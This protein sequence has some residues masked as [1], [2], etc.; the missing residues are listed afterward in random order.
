V[1]LME[2]SQGSSGARAVRYQGGSQSNRT[3]FQKDPEDLSDEKGLLLQMEV[4][5]ELPG[6]RAGI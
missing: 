4:V 3:D 1:F 6:P 5:L 2:V